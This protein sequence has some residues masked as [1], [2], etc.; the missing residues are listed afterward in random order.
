MRAEDRWLHK[1]KTKVIRRARNP[2]FR[3][4]LRYP[5][6]DAL[7][8][9]LL[10]ML[11]EKKQGFESNQGLGGCE[12]NFGQ[13]PLSGLTFGWYHLFPIHTLGTQNADSP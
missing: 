4:T 6:S 13:L 10:M 7:G 2:Q 3:Q 9:N 11:W 8:R 1:R 12:I 5:R